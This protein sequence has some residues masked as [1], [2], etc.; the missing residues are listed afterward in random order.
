MPSL[1]YQE[2]SLY[3][4]LLANVAVVLPYLYLIRNGQPSINLICGTITILI[5][6]QIIMQSII[7]VATRNRITDERDRLIELRGYR[8]GYF[9]VISFMLVGMG[10]LWL[11]STLGQLN[12][13]HMAL[14]FLSVF[15]GVLM[16][17]EVVKTITQII[18]YRRPL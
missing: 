14:H 12:P 16:L 3:G 7:A 13:A 5:L 17:A 8:A 10:M 15:F 18:S 6:A 9:T 4:A 2:R 11:H 1:S